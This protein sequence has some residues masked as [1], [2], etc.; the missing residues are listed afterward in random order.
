MTSE[1]DVKYPVA[2]LFSFV[3]GI[4]LWVL[5]FN[6]AAT[7]FRISDPEM[8]M[9]SGLMWASF[10]RTIPIVFML[11]VWIATAPFSGRIWRIGLIPAIVLAFP[12]SILLFSR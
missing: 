2:T 7:A 3:S 10:F 4:L 8:D 1:P 9:F 11:I 12:V 6:I 5:V